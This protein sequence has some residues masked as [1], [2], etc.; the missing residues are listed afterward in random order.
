MIITWYGEGCFKI[1]SGEFT[2]LTDPIDSKTGLGAPCFKADVTLKT[3]N[4]FPLTEEKDN[5]NGVLILGAGEYNIKDANI[6]G[7]LLEKESSQNFFKTVYLLEIEG[8]KICLL[9]HL[10]ETLEPA[11]LEHLEDVD[12]LII[13]AGGKPFIDEKAA[14]KLIKQIQ[15]KIIIPSFFKIP[16]LKRQSADVKNFLEELNHKKYETQEKLT[17]KKKELIEM[18]TSEVVVLKV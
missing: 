14:V 16:G 11:V 4:P 12:I 6:S 2:A 9:G 10:S 15:P 1:Q 17:I 5:E 18:K 13:P 3:I 7:L 8:I